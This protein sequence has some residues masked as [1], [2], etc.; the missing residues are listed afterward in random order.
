MDVA[1]TGREEGADLCLRC[2][3]PLPPATHVCPYCSAPTSAHAMTV[4]GEY[5]GTR[6]LLLTSGGDR[7]RG[8]LGP[9]IVLWTVALLFV[10]YLVR[11]AYDLWTGTEPMAPLEFVP[12]VVF[13]AL[14]ALIVVLALRATRRYVEGRRA[15][16]AASPAD[17]A[18]DDDSET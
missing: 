15:P 16:A 14:T 4:P 1:G 5:I 9:V 10:A 6:M 17:E 8:S 11:R 2:L 3:R 13:A 7:L 18:T 12:A